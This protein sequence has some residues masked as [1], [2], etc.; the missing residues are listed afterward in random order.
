MELTKERKIEI[1]NKVKKYIKTNGRLCFMCIAIA[2]NNCL[3]CN[4][5]EITNYIPEFT[6]E[7]FTELARKNKY[8]IP[9]RGCKNSKGGWWDINNKKIRI[10]MLNLLIKELQDV[11]KLVAKLV[12]TT[13]VTRVIVPE[14]ATFDEIMSATLPRISEQLVTELSEN[15]DDIIYDLECP[16]D[17][18]LDGE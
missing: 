17:P 12:V 4:S 1:L 8:K 10:T 18:V 11:P 16:Y 7:H 5:N 6:I 3:N 15:V 14:N 9:V 2:S 13:F